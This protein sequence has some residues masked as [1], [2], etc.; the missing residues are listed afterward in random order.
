MEELNLFTSE[1]VSEGHPDKVCDQISD[2][3]LD[4]VVEQDPTAHVACET[5]AT[6]QRIIVG[7]EIR[8]NANV[9]YEKIVRDTLRQIGYTS[10][11]LGI[12]S[13][14]C[15]VDILLHEQSEDIALGVDAETSASTS[16]GAGDQGIMFGYAC[17]ETKE[18]MPLAIMIAH[19]LVREASKQRKSGAFKWARP[20][21]KSQVTIDYTDL[22]KPKINTILMSIQHD[23]D[24]DEAEFKSYIKNEIVDKVL[25]SFKCDIEGYNL[26]INPT[27]RFVIGGPDGDSGLTGRKIIVDTYGGYARHGGGA[28]SGKDATKVDRSAAYAARWVAKNLVAAEL[29]D[30]CEIQL[31]YAI[32]VDHPISINVNTHGTNHVDEEIILKAVRENFDL[33]PAGIIEA[34]QLQRPIYKNVAAYGHMGRSDLGVPWEELNKVD[35]LKVYLN[36]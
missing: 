35:E 7:G 8:T 31:S 14:T 29:C 20:D 28:F 13:E 24:Y 5:F 25:K 10:E 16:T 9:D 3:I 26:L 21:M 32:G 2:A 1:S 36:K 19:K 22:E 18:Y 23:D 33:T 17:I 11:E 15:T 12:N 34:L 6:K 27:G 4:A 30:K